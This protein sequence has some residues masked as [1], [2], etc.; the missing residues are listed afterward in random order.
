[1]PTLCSQPQRAGLVA[2]GGAAGLVAACIVLGLG[3]RADGVRLYLGGPLLAGSWDPRLPIAAAIPVLV[4]LVVVATARIRLPWPGLLGASAVAAAAWAVSLASVDGR[5]GLLRGVSSVHDYLADVP[6]VDS[7]AGL[8]S[9]YVGNISADAADPW[10]THVGGHPPGA[11]LVFTVLDRLGLGGPGWAAALCIAV[12]VSALPAVLITARAVAGEQL[13]R[14]AAPYLVLT[15]AAVWLATSADALFLGVS[16]WGIAALAVAV[17]ATGRSADA[18]ALAGGVLLG[19][20][21][22]LSYGLMLLGPLAVA[23]VV[24][25]RRL[26]A[27]VVGALGVLAVVGAFAALGFW[28]VSGLL[29]TMERVSEGPAAMSRPSWFFLLA[30][31][32]VV[33]IAIGPAGVAGLGTAL[34]TPARRTAAVVLPLVTLAAVLLA[35]VSLLS[36]GEVERIY[37]P[38]FGWLLTATALLAPRWRTGWLLAQ[39]GTALSVQLLVRTSW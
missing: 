29:T 23:V 6:R 24:V 28:W 11:L 7:L 20:A 9:G 1:M 13:A 15:P 3:L 8:L 22:F 35:D 4:G 25:R 21:V 39:A 19:A 33:A 12:G 37:L 38:F 10:T 31:L 30:N 32:A 26:R 34:G 5:D 2:V 14:A 27:L 18:L 17:R 16:A 36:K